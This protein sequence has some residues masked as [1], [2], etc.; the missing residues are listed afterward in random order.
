MPSKLIAMFKTQPGSSKLHGDVSLQPPTKS[1]L[2]GS[3]TIACK[4]PL[5]ETM[6]LLDGSIKKMVHLWALT[7]R[8]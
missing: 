5:L 3:S 6:A 2:I 8:N 4:F 7:L 1:T